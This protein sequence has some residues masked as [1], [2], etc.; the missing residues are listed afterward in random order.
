MKKQKKV[1]LEDLKIYPNNGLA[2][3]GLMNAYEKLGDQKN[4]NQAKIR[5]DKAWKYAD[6]KINSSRIL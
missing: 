4:Y 2:L 5:F 1:Y 3:K 6:I